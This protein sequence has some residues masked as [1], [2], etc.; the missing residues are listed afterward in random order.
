[1]S[2]NPHKLP[3][4]YGPDGYGSGGFSIER[5]DGTPIAQGIP[6]FREEDAAMIC[7]AVNHAQRRGPLRDRASMNEQHN[8]DEQAEPR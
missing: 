3:W 4:T 6:A 5:A 8:N 2:D 7:R 1:M